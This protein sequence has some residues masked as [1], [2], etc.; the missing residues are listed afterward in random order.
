MMSTYQPPNKNNHSNRQVT[1]YTVLTMSKSLS[2]VKALRE[3]ETK[4]TKT[5]PN[6]VLF[7]MVGR[8]VC[9]TYY[10]GRRGGGRD[11]PKGVWN[12]SSVEVVHCYGL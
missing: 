8:G 9:T 3:E 7:V 2:W 5:E 12:T 11:G 10:P 6:T 4:F 1:G